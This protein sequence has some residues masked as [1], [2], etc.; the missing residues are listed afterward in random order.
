MLLGKIQVRQ[1][2]PADTF[3]D[4]AVEKYHKLE[5]EHFHNLNLDQQ[6]VRDITFQ[7]DG[8]LISLVSD[9]T[10]I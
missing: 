7:T 4:E 9:I 10:N 2:N 1:E 3:I 5:M 8:F 6:A